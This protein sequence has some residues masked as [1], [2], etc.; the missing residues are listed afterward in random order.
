MYEE[1]IMGENCTLALR[2]PRNPLSRK[3]PLHLSLSATNLEPSEI[4]PRHEDEQDQQQK[5]NEMKEHESHQG[6]LQDEFPYIRFPDLGPV[7]EGVFAVAEEGHE[8]VDLVL[9][10]YQEMGAEE[11]G[12]DELSRRSQR[13]ALAI[14]IIRS[15]FSRGGGLPNT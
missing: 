4:R 6:P 9:V 10:G 1:E 2:R 15:L 8:D 12:D 11:V 13:L 5:R 3:Q 7:H 14:G